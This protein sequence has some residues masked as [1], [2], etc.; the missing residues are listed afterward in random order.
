MSL[1]VVTINIWNKQGDWA[2]RRPLLD[3]ELARLQ[4]DLVGVQE[5][6]HLEGSS[7]PNQAQELAAPLGFHAAFAPAWNLGGGLLFGNAVLSR[8]PI[9][10]ADCL[11]LPGEENEE[12][13]ALL[14]CRV[15]SPH[16]PLPV[17][18]THLD[19]QL[20]RGWVRERQ[21]AFIVDRIRELAPLTGFP[22]ILMGDFN[23]EPESDEI[24]FLRGWTSRLGRSVYFADCFAVSGDG[25]PGH[26]YARSNSFAAKARE[27]N[28]RIDY[29]FVRGPDR[30]GRGEPL[31]SRL[32]FTDP[33]DGIFPTD[34]YGV[35][36]EL[37]S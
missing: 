36:A 30:D 29:V 5:V 25:S 14:Y 10:Q 1:R 11:P 8:W 35:F 37:S 33:T 32:C 16:G 12:R 34:H 26:T 4:P 21:V 28:R 22:P 19:W 23:A 20:H 3:R 15:D 7:E 6:L 24:R 18:V 31:S 17:F 13:R 9:G 27:P 2:A